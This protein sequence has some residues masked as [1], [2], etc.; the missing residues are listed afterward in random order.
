MTVPLWAALLSIAVAMCQP[1][2][3]FLHDIAP[4]KNSIRR[5]GDCSVPITLVTLGAYFFVPSTAPSIFSR[6]NLFK[7][8]DRSYAD[9]SVV[10]IPPPRTAGETKTVVSFILPIFPSTRSLIYLISSSLF[11]REW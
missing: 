4:L 3:A 1:V 9:E 5:A 2:Q 6:F 10:E 7:T 8:A 11:Y